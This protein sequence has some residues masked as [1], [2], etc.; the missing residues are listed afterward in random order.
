MTAIFPGRCIYKHSC[1]YIIEIQAI[2][3]DPGGRSFK[4]FLCF[5][6]IRVLND[7]PP[8]LRCSSKP[9]LDCFNRIVHGYRSYILRS[10]QH[11]TNSCYII[12]KPDMF[13]AFLPFI[14]SEERR[15]GKECVGRCRYRGWRWPK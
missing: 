7:L 8:V 3:E 4:C 15:V 5:G 14:R 10:S 9:G 2:L 1:S 13:L 12:T 11:K 6:K